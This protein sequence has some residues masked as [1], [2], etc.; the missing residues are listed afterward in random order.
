MCNYF[1]KTKLSLNSRNLLTGMLLLDTIITLRSIA[2]KLVGTD[3]TKKVR[4]NEKALHNHMIP[5]PVLL[6]TYCLNHK[7]INQSAITYHT[8]TITYVAKV[9]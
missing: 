1:S 7:G 8:V 4:V 6:P 5:L 3:K 9:D 2:R